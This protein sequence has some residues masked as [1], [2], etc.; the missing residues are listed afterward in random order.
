MGIIII[1]EAGVNHNGNIKLAKQMIDVA[2][3]AKADYIKF[4]TFKAKN[5]STK[6]A[7]KSEYQ[8]I[9]TKNND[10]QYDM[11]KSLELSEENHIELI[12]HCESKNIKFLS[13]AFDLESLDFVL[14]LNL[15]FVK[16]PSGEINNYLYLEKIASQKIP[17]ILSTGM[18]TINEIESAIKILTSYELSIN[19]ITILHC[20]TE[21]PTP[22]E[23]VNLKAMLKIKDH[24]KV[25]VGYSD[26][27]L[28]IEIPIAA[29][30]LGAT[31][32]EK[33]FTVDK[34]LNGPDHSSSLEPNELTEM[35][36]S[37]RNI[38]EACSGSGIKEPSSSEIKNKSIV[39]KSIYL[40]SDVKKGDKL[41]EDM[42]IALRPANGISPMEIPNLIGRIFN[43]D[44][45]K[46]SQLKYEDLK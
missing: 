40:N 18:A 43:K 42:L 33:H 37:I 14:S 28:G 24:F 23:D 21:Y 36:K 41:T 46:H 17:V 4:Q 35:I 26:H 22:M 30:A 25:N 1:A 29:V 6:N 39:R 38:E 20:N 8:K 31:I 45:K 12:K 27:T 32:I 10:T 15:D 13:S 3:N 19:N 44:L 7:E 11:L 16:I 9:N 34:T 2:S 5:L